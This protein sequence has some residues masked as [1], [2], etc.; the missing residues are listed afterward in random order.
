MAEQG[1]LPRSDNDDERAGYGAAGQRALLDLGKG[2]QAFG[3]SLRWLKQRPPHVYN[4]QFRQ[5]IREM[6]ET[7]ML[8]KAVSEDGPVIA[9]HSDASVVACIHSWSTRLSAGRIKWREDEYPPSNYEQ[10]KA[11]ILKEVEYFAE[12]FGTDL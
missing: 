4:I 3:I 1:I 10:I 6:Q 8:V 9:F 11:F 12:R 2:L 5:P 7:L